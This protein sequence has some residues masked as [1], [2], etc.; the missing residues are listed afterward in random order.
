MIL[1]R[2]EVNIEELM[3]ILAIEVRINIKVNNALRA[4]WMNHLEFVDANN[5]MV[6]GKQ[7]GL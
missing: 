2:R 7:S 5:G 4:Y 1:E 3:E 6:N